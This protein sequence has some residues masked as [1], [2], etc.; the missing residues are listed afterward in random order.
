MKHLIKMKNKKAQEEMIGFGVIIALVSIVLLVLLFFSVNSGEDSYDS[1]KVNSFVQ[2]ILSYTTDCQKY[3]GT[4]LDIEGLI[5]SCANNETC[6][7][8]GN[9]SCETLNSNLDNI[10]NSTWPAG[11][12]WPTK[13]YELIINSN[14]SDGWHTIYSLEKGSKENATRIKKGIQNLPPKPNTGEVKV[15]FTIYEKV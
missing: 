9:N 6:V 11:E 10:V 2:S 4:Y 1:E 14:E 7:N 8:N 3:Q 13:G 12:K 15:R 5:Y